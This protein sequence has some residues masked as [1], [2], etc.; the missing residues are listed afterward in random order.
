MKRF[1]PNSSGKY[2]EPGSYFDGSAIDPVA[3]FI[4]NDIP[5][6]Q[7]AT[8]TEHCQGQYPLI[9]FSAFY[10]SFFKVMVATTYSLWNGAS[11]P[12]V[13]GGK[14][15]PLKQTC[16]TTQVGACTP[17]TMPPLAPVAGVYI[18]IT[19]S[20]QTD[21]GWITESTAWGFGSQGPFIITGQSVGPFKALPQACTPLSAW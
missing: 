8:V 1:L 18:P 7:G 17:A 14:P 5:F 4:G 9:L 19:H 20:C 6:T 3:D 11:T 2:I 12:L 21:Q 15:D 10:D 16:Y 13:C